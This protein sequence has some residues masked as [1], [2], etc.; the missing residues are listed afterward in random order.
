VIKID[1]AAYY[2]LKEVITKVYVDKRLLPI[3]PTSRPGIKLESIEEIILHCSEFPGLD[4]NRV[5][6][7]FNKNKYKDSLST[8]VHYIIGLNGEVVEIIPDDEVAYHSG[9]KLVNRKSIGI[10]C[11][12]EDAEGSFSY[13]TY[14]SLIELLADL[15][16]KHNLNPLTDIKRHY[17]ITGKSCPKYYVEYPLEFEKIKR[18][19]QNKLIS[20]YVKP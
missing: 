8:S 18:D 12:H 1:H 10:E 11:I 7:S 15:M 13:A 20:D 9:N 6:E 4:V 16:K 17:D 19:V 14:N 3:N 5:I 2:L